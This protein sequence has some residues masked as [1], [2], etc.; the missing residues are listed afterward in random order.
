[1]ASSSSSS[2]LRYLDWLRGLAAVIMLQGHAYD[3]FTRPDLRDTGPFVL[4]QFVGGMPPAIFLFLTGLTLAFLMHSRER[5]G[6]PA[7]QRVLAALRRSG[8]LMTI[9]V[10][11][12]V[13]LWLFAI[14]NNPWTD[15]FKVDILNAMAI[16]VAVLSPM[17]AFTTRERARLCAILGLLIAAASPLLSQMSWPGVPV[18][19]KSYLAPDLQS[20]GFFPWASFLAFGVS[21]GSILKLTRTDQTDRLIQWGALL[22]VVLVVGGRYFSEIPYSLYSK[23]DFWLDSPSMV[24]IKLGV[25]LLLLALAFLW[26]RYVAPEKWSWVAQFGTTSLLVYWV[27]IELIY[28]KWFWYWKENL[29]IPQATVSA[30]L[31]VLFMLGLSVVKTNWKSWREWPVAFLFPSY[32]PPRVSGD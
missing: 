11:F 20:F 8:Y 13:Q 14:P 7:P 22:G 10:L 18:I 28:G 31:L 21:A 3:S 15:I 4:S 19:I 16:A 30:V 12:R 26:T 9:A 5:Q 24:L 23:S 27:H 32:E 25:I 29:T 6:L 1:M 17:A 2:R